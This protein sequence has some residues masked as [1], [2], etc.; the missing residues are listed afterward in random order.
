MKSTYSSGAAECVEV[1]ASSG[2]ICIRDSKR[3]RGP[4]LAV[5]EPAWAAFIGYATATGG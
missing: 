5:P 1:A 2:A 3:I 4:Q